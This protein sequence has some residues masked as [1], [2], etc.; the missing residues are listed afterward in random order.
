MRFQSALRCLIV[1]LAL[2]ST[3]LACSCLSNRR[4]EQTPPPAVAWTGRPYIFVG[5][6]LEVLETRTR[7]PRLT[8]RFV[9]E[10]SWRGPMR[11]TVT[12][13][14]RNDAPCARYTAGGRYL[15]VADRDTASPSAL[16]TGPCDDSWIIRHAGHKLAALGAP[17]WT[18]P[19]IGER[20][21]DAHVVRLGESRNPR[22]V[23]DSL[24]M[25]V[26][27]DA[28]IA[29]FEIADW[30][31]SPSPNGKLIYLTAGLY[32]FRITWTD[33]TTYESY[34][35]LR[36]ESPRSEGA[37]HVFRFFSMLRPAA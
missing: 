28:D 21:L 6:V 10:M 18:A 35:L 15:V 19:R 5:H 12:L 4:V 31:G 20:A 14:V 1:F 17:N 2:P 27:S 30:A 7:S 36:C 9:T 8:V 25:V 32:Q 3:A 34:V 16:V 33:G 23:A 13:L 26:P 29:R 11:D 24:V 37:C 22:L